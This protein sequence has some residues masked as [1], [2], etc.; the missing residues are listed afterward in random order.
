MTKATLI[1]MEKNEY[2]IGVGMA[3]GLKTGARENFD[4][5]FSRMNR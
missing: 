2:E 5:I 1:R 3:E 4:Q